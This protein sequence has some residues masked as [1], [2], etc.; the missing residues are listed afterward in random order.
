MDLPYISDAYVVAVPDHDC[1]EVAGALVKIRRLTMSSAR[2]MAEQVVSLAKIRDDLVQRIATH[3]LPAMLRILREGEGV[4]R[5]ASE[6]SS[7]RDFFS[8]ISVLKETCPLIM[9]CP[10]WRIGEP[11]L[12][13]CQLRYEG[14]RIGV[15][16][17]VLIKPATC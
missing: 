13:R 14:P 2:D 8:S 12:L 9:R 6:E 16:C 7:K 11:S 17:S 10:V 3:K 4:P 5:T 15:G 1:K